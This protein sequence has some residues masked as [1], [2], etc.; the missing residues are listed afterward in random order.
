MLLRKGVAN[1]KQLRGRRPVG[2]V[3]KD[4]N[5]SSDQRSLRVGSESVQALFDPGWV[6]KTVRVSE[7]KSLATGFRDPS[8]PG[9]VRTGPRLMQQA[10]LVK[11]GTSEF[12]L[13]GVVDDN[14]LKLGGR[15]SLIT[16]CLKAVRQTLAFTEGWHDH[17]YTLHLSPS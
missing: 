3:G 14:Y 2:I 1:L 11:T 10:S 15:A 16:E 4:L 5:F 12:E 17:A 8:I 9:S 7:R 6:R 13:G